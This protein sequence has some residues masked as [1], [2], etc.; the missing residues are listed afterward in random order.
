MV[1]ART[2]CELDDVAASPAKTEAFQAVS[3]VHDNS[4]TA[5]TRPI[6]LLPWHGTP[7]YLYVSYCQFGQHPW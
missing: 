3:G 5:Y 6:W 2:V 4:P 1:V 7:V